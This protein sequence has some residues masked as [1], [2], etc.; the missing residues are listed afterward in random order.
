VFDGVA[1]ATP[2]CDPLAE[3]VAVG[4]SLAPDGS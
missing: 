1:I 4:D 2:P 3:A